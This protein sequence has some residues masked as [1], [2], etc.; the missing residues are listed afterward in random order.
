[1]V[2]SV[3]PFNLRC[4]RS[5]HTSALCSIL[6]FGLL[7]FGLFR[8]ATAPRA[9]AT[10]SPRAAQKNSAQERKDAWRLLPR[11]DGYD[12]RE[13]RRGEAHWYEIP[14]NRN[15]YARVAV[16]LHGID[17]VLTV[18]APDGKMLEQVD[19]PTFIE[20]KKSIMW[21][22][23]A[24]GS[25]QL[26]ARSPGTE[27]TPGYYSISVQRSGQ[28]TE[29]NR[30]LILADR[31]TAE[32]WRLHEIGTEEA[33]RQA[34]PKL[35]E[36][37]S[38]WRAA[39]QLAHGTT[40]LEFL[41]E[42]ISRE[43][44]V[45][46]LVLKH[47]ANALMYLG[48]VYFGLSDYEKALDTYQQA[49]EVWEGKPGTEG[50]TYN[51]IGETYSARGDKQRALENFTLS[52]RA[53]EKRN[54]HQDEELAVGLTAVGSFY[55]SIRENEKA[56][57]YLNRAALLSRQS[58][59]SRREARARQLIGEIQF[60]SGDY[61]AALD[62]FE[63]ARRVWH[64]T[65]HL[66]PESKALD[67]IGVTHA[68]LGDHQ[69]A[70]DSLT[71]ALRVSRVAGDRRGEAQ[72]RTDLGAVYFSMGD[73][74]KALAH[75]LEALPLRRAVGD[76]EGEA[77]TLYQIARAERDQGKLTESRASLE[78]ALMIVEDVRTALT[79]EFR[80]QYFSTVAD[81]YNLYIDLLMRLHRSNP[82]AG[83]EALALQAGER[84]R[85][86]SLLETLA[87]AKVDLT[88]GVDPNLV[89]QRRKLAQRLNARAEYRSRLQ[90]QGAAEQVAAVTREIDAIT[91]DY[92][93]AEGL[94]R[95]RSP[96]YAAL[97][98]PKPLS[99]S[100]IQQLLDEDTLLLEYSL[101][102]ERSYLWAVSPKSF[103][104]YELPPRR[105]IE[106]AAR[107]VYDLVTARGRRL[108][109]ESDKQYR[110]RVARADA[111]FTVAA[112][113]LSRILVGSVAEKLGNKRL[114]IVTEGALQFIPFGALP[115]PVVGHAASLRPR[116]SATV[117]S[118]RALRHQPLTP[119]PQP[120][121]VRHDIVSLAS[122]SALAIL[123][124]ELKDRKPA[125]RSIA[126]LADPVFS[127]DDP[128]VQQ[129]FRTLNPYTF[130]QN[131]AKRISPTPSRQP[132]T[133]DNATPSDLER[134]IEDVDGTE[135]GNRI[136]RL[137]ATR[138]EAQQITSFTPAGKQAL[139]FAASREAATSSEM[140]QYR[141]IHFATHALI[142]S[143][144]PELSGIVLSLVDDEGRPKD[145]FLRADDIFNLKLS[146]DLV[147]LSAC[148]TGL[149]KDV[150]GEGLISLTRGFMYAG[151]PRVVV[152]LWRVS[153][154][155]TAEFMA[156]FYRRI[157]N[158]SGQSPSSALRQAQLEMLK[159]KRWQS[160][161][162]W[163]GFVLQGEWR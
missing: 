69:K 150:R 138:W 77:S 68:A 137:L 128:R 37:W 27:D 12:R 158:G 156:R 149:G 18:F 70:L 153:D 7:P 39:A 19:T 51:N 84:A 135:L 92:Q 90:L 162:F 79:P 145:G 20:G 110:S 66:L 159:D 21:V 22:S 23:D 43:T 30:D 105:E 104:S 24:A 6:I 38:H 112:S 3:A 125:P 97:T 55:A 81:Y 118:R 56:L 100:Q 1:L 136:P 86:R 155:A 109:R 76:R 95:A 139:D 61:H 131:K 83:F 14:L 64:D 154:Q 108:N 99:A 147:V 106:A 122:A 160:P 111:E 71:E 36:A 40:A 33:L 89:E 44:E 117:K 50:W 163:A 124:Q 74:E 32:G 35:E 72:A 11:G 98:Q 141:I 102:D 15:Q 63:Q 73:I 152:S 161:Y 46:Y 31:L 29:E 148:R 96:R 88:Q 151:A 49:L 45:K 8:A 132:P 48:E 65:N 123:R 129:R 94:M 121:I 93:Q 126:V 75:C 133:P 116:V 85:A 26:E 113:A 57:D 52:L 41:G 42:D 120:L 67:S 82:A 143:V 58:D 144:H 130:E 107:R 140:G 25:Y 17:I 146:A 5:Q 157:L 119:N 34:I 115:A 13:L 2:R 134:A 59:N 78:Q 60:A 62:S 91:L 80:P 127:A 9:T 47:G 103:T 4:S 114:V 28:A 54:A 10:A 142:D 16:Y 87:E 53:Y 101:G